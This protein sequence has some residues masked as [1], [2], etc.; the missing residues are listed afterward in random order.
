MDQ[1]LCRLTGQIHVRL[2][3]S[4][5]ELTLLVN[6]ICNNRFGLQLHAARVEPDDQPVYQHETR[7]MAIVS[8][9]AAGITEADDEE[10]INCHVSGIKNAAAESEL[11]KR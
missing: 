10:G 7:I 6:R 3:L 4:K 1:P 2:R 8:V 9:F 5:D 11:Q